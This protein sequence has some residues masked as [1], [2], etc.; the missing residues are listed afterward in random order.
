VPVKMMIFAK[1]MSMKALQKSVCILVLLGTFTTSIAQNLGSVQRG[2][3]GYT[4]PPRALE[5]GEPE[6]PDVIVMAQASATRYAQELK[7]DAFKKE[8]LKS[9]LKDF[10]RE[11]VDIA[12]N[13]ELKFDEKQP[14]II[15]ANARFEK[16]LVEILN[17]EQIGTLMS[18]EQL[19]VKPNDDKKDTKKKK[20]KKRKK[21]KN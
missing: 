3:R 20:R 11:K 9:Y 15:E 14:M 16:K 7:I 19:G 2:Q 4:P 21:N 8:V 12:Y 10:Y 13:P 1:I 17:A 6:K 5:A 18:Y